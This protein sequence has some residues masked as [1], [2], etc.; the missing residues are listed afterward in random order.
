[1]STEIAFPPPAAPPYSASK[2]SRDRNCFC[3]AVGLCGARSSGLCFALRRFLSASSA[4]ISAK[5][6]RFSAVERA[7]VSR[8]Y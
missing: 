3:L 2:Q 7:R 6:F 1:M 5:T 8:P 4:S